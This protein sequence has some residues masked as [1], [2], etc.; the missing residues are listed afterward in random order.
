M[1]LI[2]LQKAFDTV[3]HEILFNKLKAMG[4]GFS[5]WFRSYLTN[6]KQKVKVNEA[7]SENLITCGLPEGSILG[8]LLL[9]GVK[10]LVQTNAIC[11]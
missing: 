1:V 4:I 11:R 8:P 5:A 2:D 9:H 7:T 6:R 10:C 3:D